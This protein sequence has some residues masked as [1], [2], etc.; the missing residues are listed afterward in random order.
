MSRSLPLYK[1]PLSYHLQKNQFKFKF[2]WLLENDFEY[3]TNT[4]Y[5]QFIS[6]KVLL[7]YAMFCETCLPILLQHKLH[8]KMQIALLHK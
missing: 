8:G 5:L 7:H 1:H 2:L 6:F 3:H 4:T